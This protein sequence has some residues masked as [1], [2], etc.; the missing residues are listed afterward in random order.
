MHEALKSVFNTLFLNLIQQGGT[1]ILKGLMTFSSELG[2]LWTKG[3][4][5]SLR[6]SSVL[7]HFFFV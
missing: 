6:S 3:L 2:Q 5:N 4:P 1:I 7:C